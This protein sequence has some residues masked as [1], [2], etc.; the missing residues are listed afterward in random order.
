MFDLIIAINLLTCFICRTALHLACAQG[1]KE[2]VA[3]L[4]SSKAKLNLCD[5]DQR[6]PL[7][8]V[9]YEKNLQFVVIK[10]FSC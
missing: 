10:K 4:V 8:K 2:L 5:N 9:F 3:F 7:M 1:H 6:S